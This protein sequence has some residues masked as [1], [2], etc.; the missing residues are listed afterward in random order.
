MST[1]YQ[2]PSRFS[3]AAVPHPFKVGSQPGECDICGSTDLQAPIHR[4]LTHNPNADEAERLHVRETFNLREHMK[5]TQG[6]APAQEA[7]P[8]HI[9]KE[10]VIILAERYG[11]HVIDE[12]AG[13]HAIHIGDQLK[14][15][16]DQAAGLLVRAQ[17]AEI[18]LAATE[19][20]AVAAEMMH[21]DALRRI[22][23]IEASQ[24]KWTVDF[25]DTQNYRYYPCGCSAMGT[26]NSLPDK[27]PEHP[28]F[29]FTEETPNV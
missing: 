12:N 16:Q 14:V 29:P 26:N 13:G 15:A 28:N 17:S 5:Q 18:A 23:E 24:A 4:V 25:P 8:P 22:V 2:T 21:A 6:A 3:V 11:L 20:R 9:S 10:T 1:G 7:P 27:C 19:K